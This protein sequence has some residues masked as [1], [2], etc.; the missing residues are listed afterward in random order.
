MDVEAAL[1]EVD[2]FLVELDH[3]RVLAS[4][5]APASVEPFRGSEDAVTRLLPLVR[6]IARELDPNLASRLQA[7]AGRW[8]WLQARRA[9][10]ELQGLLQNAARL[11]TILGP[12]GPQL[13][14]T[15][16]HPAVWGPAASLWDGRYY[17][18]AVQAAATVVDEHL[19]ARLGRDDIT[20][21]PLVT[22][23]FSTDPPS[24]NSPRLRFRG[25][26]PNSQTWQSLHEGAMFFGRG[27]ML[28]IRNPVTHHSAE[29]EPQI[30]LEQLAALSVLARWIDEAEV[31]T[32]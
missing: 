31:V 1:Y 19:Q 27:C 21:A 9:A 25:I 10:V 5:T 29:L 30:A 23:A 12:T 6:G 26:P 22:Q 32:A 11:A 16:L 14:A 15:G 4:T 17:R 8:K 24:V 28:A 20:G 2:A 18:H 13:A 3:N 7:A